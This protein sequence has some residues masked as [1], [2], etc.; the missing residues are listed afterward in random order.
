MM[1]NQDAGTL[2]Q[3]KIFGTKN[4]L[5][6]VNSSIK[7]KILEIL[8]ENERSGAE[9]V[10]LTG[11]SKATISA[12]LNDLVGMGIIESKP[13][14]K[15]GRSKIFFIKSSYLGDL[16]RKNDFNKE[17]DD[18]I[19]EGVVN[20]EDPFAFFRFVF[21]TFRVALIEEGVNIDPILHNA[22]IKVGETF[23]S[24]LKDS[25]TDRFIENIADFWQKNKLG[26][27]KTETLEPLTLKAYDCFE[28]EDLPKIGRSACAFDSG[29]LEAIF[30]A[31]FG[32]KV[33]VDEIKC[34]AKGDDY[35][36]F[37]VK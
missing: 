32:R 8:E 5:N 15:D 14:P 2:N 19:T 23:Y 11:K 25:Q 27:I 33:D 28:C 20:S 35:C 18:Y 10:K 13:N 3:I 16:T 26:K 24:K 29:I 34:F 12:H 21:R 7:S 9:I 36:S 31:H 30:S 17:L 4:G 6:I 37:V 22:G 1:T